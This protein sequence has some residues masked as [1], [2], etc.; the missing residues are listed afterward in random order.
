[1]TP[2]TVPHGLTNTGNVPL[3]FLN[4]VAPTGDAPITSVE[5]ESA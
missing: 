4:I 5:L 1:M 2:P 3:I